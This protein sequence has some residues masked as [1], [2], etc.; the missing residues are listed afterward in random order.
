MVA[1]ETL[2]M[3]KDRKT[4]PPPPRKL[5][6]RLFISERLDKKAGKTQ[7]WLA[8]ETGLSEPYISLLKT[9]KRPY[10]QR[11]EELLEAA[12]KVRPGALRHPPAA[13]ELR[14]RLSEMDDT[15]RNAFADALGELLDKKRP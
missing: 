4:L 15:E 12:F 1:L 14:Q 10:N 9:G 3:A 8:E 11:T 13:S 6:K 5:W 7:A 2:P